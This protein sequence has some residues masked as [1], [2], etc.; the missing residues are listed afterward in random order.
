M[1]YL[2]RDQIR[3]F[4]ILLSEHKYDLLTD[5][6]KEQNQ[7]EIEAYN[8]LEKI[9][10]NSAKDQRRKGRTSQDD[11]SDLKKRIVSKYSM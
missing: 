6:S 7:K 9:L 2:T 8:N 10:D 3:L 1:Q 5:R 4:S 11:I